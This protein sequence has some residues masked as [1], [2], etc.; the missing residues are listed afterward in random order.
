MPLC[1]TKLTA[2]MPV[3]RSLA[4]FSLEVW[5]NQSFQVNDGSTELLGLLC[6]P[7]CGCLGL[8]WSEV[9]DGGRRAFYILSRSFQVFLE[10]PG[11]GGEGSC[12]LTLGPVHSFQRIHLSD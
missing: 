4:Q 6:R 3:N 9:V 1:V 12:L 7:D 5:Q 2:T 11:E 8:R 10:C